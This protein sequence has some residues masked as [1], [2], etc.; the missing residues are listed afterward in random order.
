VG[1]IHETMGVFSR[2]LTKLKDR[3]AVSGMRTF[4][5]KGYRLYFII[6]GDSLIIIFNGGDKGNQARDISRAKEMLNQLE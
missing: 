2:W 6:K 4:V 5:G 1:Y 3:Q